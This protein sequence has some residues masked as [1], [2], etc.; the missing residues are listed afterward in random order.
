MVQ[1]ASIST[2]VAKCA[3][4]IGTCSFLQPRSPLN[5]PTSLERVIYHALCA[6]VVLILDRLMTL[7]TKKFNIYFE[8]PVNYQYT[9]IFILLT[10]RMQREIPSDLQ[11]VKLNRLKIETWQ[12]G[13]GT[14][15]SVRAKCV[16]GIITGAL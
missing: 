3:H 16:D 14:R 15:F 1:A 13:S 9:V 12:V 10:S 5:G 6:L 4:L 2:G 7:E 11:S 8:F